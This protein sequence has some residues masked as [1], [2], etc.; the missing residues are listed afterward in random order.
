MNGRAD[1]ARPVGNT[2][3]RRRFVR[4]V[5]PVVPLV[6]CAG[7]L[8]AWGLVAH[9]SGAGWVQAV[10]DVLAGILGVGL[11]APAVVAGRAVVAILEVPSDTTAGLPLE[12]VATSDTRL[13]VRPLDPPGPEAFIGPHRVAA[14]G[15]PRLAWTGASAKDP[16]GD[17][18]G[19]V[20][21]VPECRGVHDRVVLE[22]ASA[23][24]FGLL[25]WRRTVV[26]E[27]PRSVHVG[28][29]LGRPLAL[30]GG[31]EDTSGGGVLDS[32]VPIGEPRGVRPYRPGD[33]RRWV[34]W[35]ATAHSGELMVREMEGP[36]AEPVT[37]EIHLPA[38]AD[39]A[40]RMAERA[41]A[42]VV[43][44]VDRGASVLL[45]TTEASGPKIGAVGDRRS[46][47]RRLARAV[48]EPD[49]LDLSTPADTRAAL[50]GQGARNRRGA[51]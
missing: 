43:G 15:G 47:G 27:L 17:G 7:V 24:P 30:P 45:A 8:L 37:V 50:H 13:R 21:L 10:G 46:A 28:P 12:L 29:R 25:W 5:R 2:A 20:T 38:D 16:G 23:A 32:S 22:I 18:A 35:P 44:L 36:T 41:M 31:R 14:G 1:R 33:H 11:V 6:S 9:N 40:E 4:P 3:R 48:S 39:A 26:V 19:S 34:H 42:T 51:R 49:G